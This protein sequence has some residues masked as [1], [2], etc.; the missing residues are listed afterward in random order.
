MP[1]IDE[2]ASDVDPRGGLFA[3]FGNSAPPVTMATVMPPKKDRRDTEGMTVGLM[4]PTGA[5]AVARL[6]EVGRAVPDG[7]VVRQDHVR[8]GLLVRT[9]VD[10]DRGRRHRLVRAGRHRVVPGRDD[11]P[12][13]GRG[14]PSLG[15]YGGD[16][17]RRSRRGWTGTLGLANP[18]L[19]RAV[20]GRSAAGEGRLR[21]VSHAPGGQANET[22]LVDLGPA[23]PGMVVRLPPLEATYPDYDLGPQALVQNAVAAAGVPA[24]APA[25]VESDPEWI[26]SPF[27][28]M[29]RV[30]GDIPGP[31]PFF[32]PYVRDAGPAFQRIMEDELIDAVADVHAVD[33]AAHGLG[34]ALPGTA[35]ARDPR[36]LGDVCGVVL[37][38]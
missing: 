29:P 28:V 2:D 18:D 13:A 30:E 37:G 38:W 25:L 3:F 15:G 10:V 33:W 4:H 17:G 34:A 14:L 24:P 6:A 35:A 32:D 19:V 8:R 26:G 9:P 5:K 21:T 36:A 20:A 31:A 22:L 1:G 11:G 27:L 7:W 16:A 23:H 12:V